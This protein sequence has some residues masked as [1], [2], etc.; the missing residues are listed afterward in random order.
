[1]VL[2]FFRSKQK[3]NQK[4]NIKRLDAKMASL[5]MLLKSKVKKKA[6]HYRAAMPHIVRKGDPI[7]QAA[8]SMTELN[9]ETGEEFQK[10]FDLS[11]QLNGFMKIGIEKA[12]SSGDARGASEGTGKSRIASS[13]AIDPNSDFMTTDVKNEFTIIKIMNEIIELNKTLRG[14]LTTYNASVK[15]KKDKLPVP[16]LIAFP[17][18]AE[19]KRIFSTVRVEP[20]QAA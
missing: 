4:E 1:M 16:Q 17:D 6:Q 19:L 3:G 12:R 18:L 20:K 8:T 7:D 13:Y 2:K 5:R 14:K 15:R 10:Y 11:K 9:F